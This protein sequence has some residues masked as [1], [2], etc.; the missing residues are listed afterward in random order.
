MN[1]MTPARRFREL[2]AQPEIVVAPGAYDAW[3]AK[4]I[5]RAGLPR[6]RW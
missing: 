6:K 5:E 4:L 2:L 1:D 3:S